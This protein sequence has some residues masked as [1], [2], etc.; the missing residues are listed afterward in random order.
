[1]ADSDDINNLKDA[2]TILATDLIAIKRGKLG[3]DVAP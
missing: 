2:G 1:M 3:M